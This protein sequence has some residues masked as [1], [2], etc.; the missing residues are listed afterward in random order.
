MQYGTASKTT[1]SFLNGVA[2]TPKGPDASAQNNGTAWNDLYIANGGQSNSSG[3]FKFEGHIGEI[4]IY[5][6]E[7]SA[8][9]RGGVEAWLSNKYGVGVAK[10]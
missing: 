7:L 3:D 2:M 1:K 4:L 5:N 9:D 6:T 10:A 8:A